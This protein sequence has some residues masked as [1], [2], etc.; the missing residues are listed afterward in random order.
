M[1]EKELSAV[2][3]FKLPAAPYSVEPITWGNINRT[4][5]V[6]LT[7]G[8]KYVL[9]N[10]NVN[11]FKKPNELMSNVKG[12]CDFLKEKVTAA[13]GDPDRETVTYAEAD[14]GS[15]LYVDGDG[16]Y[17]RMSRFIEAVSYQSIA[18][19]ILFHNAA[20]AFG[21]FQAQLADY[22]ADTL[23]E[24]IPDFHNTVSRFEAFERAL[25]ECKNPERLEECKKECEFLKSRESLAHI[26]VDAIAS[27]KMPLRVTHNDTKLNN[28]LLDPITDKALCVIDLD[29]VMPG[30]VLYD[31]GDAIRFGACT[32][33][34][35][36][37]NTSKIALDLGL[38]EQFTRG[39]ISGLGGAL[40]DLEYELLPEGAMI[41]TYELA[42]RFLTD[43]LDGDTY[44]K[45][46]YPEH[47]IV[48]TRAQIALLTDMEKKLYEMRSIVKRCR[49]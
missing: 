25:S 19:P 23:F 20:Q 5:T 41:M 6:F 9:Q 21:K 7:N 24:T 15:M 29:T 43:Y 36:E 31:F 14:N 17:W 48:R 38:F 13:G 10:V 44:F 33:A 1:Y 4:F 11:V 46:N 27:G 30:S 37:P 3:H 49:G 42:L 47:N 12:V 32:A 2:S 45:L 26:A 22:P 18:R 35:D 39:F 28:V 34:E 40:T 16:K 8:T